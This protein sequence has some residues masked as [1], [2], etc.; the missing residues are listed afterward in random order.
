[1]ERGNHTLWHPL[2]AGKV[3]ELLGVNGSTGLSTA[4]VLRRQKKFGPNRVTARRETPAWLTFL[5]Q[6][7]QPLVYVLLLACGVTAFLGEW[8][9][10]SVIFG[11]VLI[12]AIVGF[13]QEFK[14]EK[15]IAA[16]TQLIATEATVRRDGRQQ[17]VHS[18]HLVPGDV[19]ALS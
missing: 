13:L 18:A 16:L 7:N 8:V 11:V 19:V 9:D 14:A 4:E 15:A 10:S 17:R 1:M 12:N 6:F 3:V 5:Q 2:S